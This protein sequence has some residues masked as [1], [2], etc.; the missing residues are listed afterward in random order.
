MLHRVRLFFYRPPY[1]PVH[2]VFVAG[3]YKNARKSPSGVRGALCVT[4]Q[5]LNFIFLLFGECAFNYLTISKQDYKSNSTYSTALVA[6][7]NI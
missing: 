1:L 6:H 7:F 5:L 3:S 4:L 2:S